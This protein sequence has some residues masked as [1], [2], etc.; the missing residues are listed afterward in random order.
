MLLERN[1]LDSRKSPSAGV[2][3]QMEPREELNLVQKVCFET[4]FII[5]TC[6]FSIYFVWHKSLIVH[7][8]N[9]IWLIKAKRRKTKITV[10]AVVFIIKEKKNCKC[11]K[12]EF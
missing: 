11:I 5:E 9:K 3:Y 4:L 10:N 7:I 6:L 2:I 8:H 12:I 1:P